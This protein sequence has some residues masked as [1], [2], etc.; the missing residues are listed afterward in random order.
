MIERSVILSQGLTL[1]VPL[2]ELKPLSATAAAVPTLKD[3]EREHVL[4]ALTESQ[5]VIAGPSGAA[6]KLGMKRTSLQYKM[7]K[8]GIT[9]P[10]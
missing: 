10:P 8:L 6:V 5:W 3:I 9:R 7:Q 4:N 2:G 1:E